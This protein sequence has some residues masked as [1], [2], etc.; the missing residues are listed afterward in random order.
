MTRSRDEDTAFFG[1]PS[2]LSTLFF[3]EMWERFSYYGM[4]ALLILFMTASITQGGLGF[5][6]SKAGAVY[7]AYTSM[8]YMLALPGG[9]IADRVLG[10]RRAVFYGGVL[11]MAGHVSL[12]IP[13]VSAFY[14]GLVLV[15]LGTGLLKPNISAL[16]GTL[17]TPDDVR[18]DA[19][20]SIYYMGINLGGFIAPLVTGWLAQGEGFRGFL[21][22]MG[23]AAE[24]AWHWGFGAAAVGMFFGL[25]QYRFG[26]KRLGEGGI[27][28]GGA[29]T[30]EEQR[31]Q[32]KKL[33]TG[34]GITVALLGGIGI[35]SVVGVVAITA[36][37]V[38]QVLG[39]GVVAAAGLFFLWL[40]SSR[41]WSPDERR[42]LI[43]IF[44]LFLGAAVFW[45]A[46]EQAGSTLNLFADRSTDTRI[47]GVGFPASWFQSVNSLFI[48]LLAPVMAWLWVK[49]GRRDPS[50]PTK[51]A[52][53][54]F[55]LS[56]GFGVM[57][58]AGSLAANG[59]QVSPLWLLV[60]YL[61]HTIGELALSP[62]GLSA[63]TKL[64]PA[65][66]TGMMMGVWFMASAVGNLIAGAFASIYES[67]TLPQLFG[68][69]TGFS[70]IFCLV[71]VVLISPI[72]KMLARP[73]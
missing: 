29:V 46:F 14:L 11:I 67:F 1:H 59:A 30:P 55:F 7:G 15:V 50:S 44:V 35:L 12:A 63:M 73:T 20:F 21:H 25:V 69:V 57:I 60:T 36:V 18:R 52:L 42:R 41:G 33:M 53:G 61:L 26:S 17:Y 28:P 40:F 19:G 2:G 38:A 22:G 56:A 47:F 31:V 43:V 65:R 5:D 64:A 4:R 13:S 62:V 16:V 49:L 68:A 71:M 27:V 48:I 6:V 10:L 23:I 51:F 8:V 3:T 9:W 54:L 37:G 32:R 66:V 24:S 39:V 45:S 34:L 70:L 58:V 72:K